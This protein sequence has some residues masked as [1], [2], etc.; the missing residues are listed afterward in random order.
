MNLSFQKF[1]LRA[2]FLGPIA[3]A[4]MLVVIVFVSGFIVE[5]RDR[6]DEDAQRTF[7]S[8]QRLYEGALE[9]EA[10]KLAAVMDVLREDPALRDALRA[11]D[12][13]AL[14]RRAQP[15]FA[16]LLDGYGI[17][18][19][20]FHGPD[21]VNLLRSHLPER[22]GDR[23]DRFTAVQA[24]RTGRLAYGVELGPLG[25]FT[26]RVVT[27]WVDDGRLLGYLE[28][29]M[30]IGHVFADLQSDL[31]VAP[32]VAIDKRFLVRESWTQGMRMLGSPASWDTL[33]DT[34]I[35]Y[36]GSKALPAPA[37]ALLSPA[38]RPAVGNTVVS[39]GGRIFRAATFPLKNAAGQV[40]GRM[41]FLRDTTA[42]RESNVRRVVLVAFVSLA[43][44]A[45]LFLFFHVLARRLE[46]RLEN[47]RLELIQEAR[48]RD[49]FQARHIREL[50]EKQANLV[51]AQETLAHS[52]ER[53]RSLVET[54]SDWIWETDAEGTYVYASPKVESLLGYRAEEVVGKTA[55]DFMPAGEAERCRAFFARVVAE[56]RPFSTFLNKCLNKDGR[57]VILETSAIPIFG[58]DG[59]L[60]GYRGIDRDVTERK[61]AEERLQHLAYYDGLTGLPNRSLLRD[62][63]GQAMR[64]ADRR[65]RLL[66]VMFLD[67]D[68]FSKINDTLGY[69]AGDELLKAVADLLMGC[70][71]ATDTVA[72]VGGD[73]FAIILTDI[74]HVEDAVA[75]IRKVLDRFRTPV[76]IRGDNEFFVTFCIGITLYPQDGGDVDAL[77][78]N[79]D[80]AMYN[81]R[82]RGRDNYQFYSADLAAR[83]R[84]RLA[85]ETGLHHALE[86]GELLLYYQPQMELAT[87][88]IT[89]VETLLRW[90]HPERGLVSPAEFI[91][92]AEET[93]LIVPIGEWVLRTACREIKSWHDRGFSGLRLAVNL[94]SRQFRDQD[95]ASMVGRILEETG[96]DPRCLELEITEG[97][98]MEDRVIIVEIL[99]ALKAAGVVISIDDF[100][101]GFSSLSYLKRLPIGKLK[102]DQSF[103]REMVSNAEDAAIVRTV[104]AMAHSLCISVIAE[105]VETAEQMKFLESEHCDEIQG[106]LLSRPVPAAEA[107]RFL[108]QRPPL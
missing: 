79:T 95:L 49:E 101:T 60:R 93:G 24:E 11:R 87:R 48:K 74:R 6:T 19:F 8:A 71:R 82:N 15:F 66:A 69:E 83:G 27:P 77:L 102:I 20:Y 75:M 88:R 5:E 86:R 40:V 52:Q 96:F 57:A 35:T 1:G 30:E 13:A 65:K 34:V 38:S 17:T 64:D 68:Q 2:Q 39:E 94:S 46:R 54:T 31:G 23:I 70:V 10:K 59:S 73:E 9:K 25:I 108:E 105:G 41:L 32:Y 61:N 58:G 91:P 36:H 62:R 98:L 92:L 43:V 7:L 55:F 37:L 26:L 90:S 45:T 100:G 51:A 18:H 50:E 89:G 104:I 76:R 16:R 67:L 99:N 12:R 107:L 81:A 103:V 106:F 28:L 84:H 22:F 44:G 3:L 4:L 56:R 85:L 63:L 14:S 72:R 29:G 47:S 42:T 21:R 33:A 80:S 53:F 78:Q 97:L